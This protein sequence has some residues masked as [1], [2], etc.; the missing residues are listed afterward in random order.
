M[1]KMSWVDETEKSMSEERSKEYFNIVEGDNRFQVL[2]HCVPM[3]QRWTGKKYEPAEIGEEGASIKGVCWVL[4]DDI[5]KLAKLPYTVVKSIRAFQNDEETS[6]D[7]FPMPYA[8][9][10]KAKGAGTKE[11]EY[12]VIPS[13]KE[14][15]V[16][17]EVLDELAKKPS[18]EDMVEKI[19][20]K[21]AETAAKDDINPDDIP[22]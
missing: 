2:T 16:T 8:I 9:N 3:A 18:P 6:F 1:D 22:F 17:K 4:Q 13:R 7:A 14:T 19:K 21:K 11:V 10:V 12:T 5:L 15:E 20:G